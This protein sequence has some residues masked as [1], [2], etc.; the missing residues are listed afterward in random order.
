MKNG[1]EKKLTEKKITNLDLCFFS[2][3]F[4]TIVSS[5]A[6]FNDVFYHFSGTIYYSSFFLLSIATTPTVCGSIEPLN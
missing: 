2:P 3:F 5:S 4:H 1:R 6:E